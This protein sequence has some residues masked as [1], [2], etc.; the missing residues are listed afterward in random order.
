MKTTVTVAPD[1]IR[2]RVQALTALHVFVKDL[3]R[4]PLTADQNPAVNQAIVFAFSRALMRL[5]GWVDDFVIDPLDFYSNPVDLL[6]LEVTFMTTDEHGRAVSWP[7]VRRA[8]EEY[9]SVEVIRETLPDCKLV[10]FY[11]GRAAD[12]LAELVQTIEMPAG[13]CPPRIAR[14][15]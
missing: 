5:A 8:L 14:T 11:A 4:S 13:G 2:A 12:A 6:M 9:V 10:E 3:D 7:L 15:I 1:V